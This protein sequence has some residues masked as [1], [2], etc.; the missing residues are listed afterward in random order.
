[1]RLRHDPAILRVMEKRCDECLYSMRKIVSD[2]RRD[3]VLVHCERTET[4]FVCHKGSLAGVDVMCRG[5]W[6]LTK[7]ATLRNRLAQHLGVV[8]FV[9]MADLARWASRRA[10]IIKE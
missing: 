9:R 8:R 4:H 10:R 2:E 1:M 5:H 7:N 3:E 6:D